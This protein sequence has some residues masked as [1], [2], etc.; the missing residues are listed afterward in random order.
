MKRLAAL[1]ALALGATILVAEHDAQAAPTA[2]TACQTISQPGSY[3][4]AN[5][6]LNNFGVTCLVITTSFVTIDLAGFSIFAD[7]RR[8]VGIKAAPSSGQLE[9]IAVRNG[10]ISGVDLSS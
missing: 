4:L 1:F 6:L 8:G 3:Q 2:I 10:S 7:P 9:G 5:N